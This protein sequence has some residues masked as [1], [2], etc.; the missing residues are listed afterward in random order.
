M[1]PNGSALGFTTSDFPSPHNE[2]TN[3]AANSPLQA[4]LTDGPQAVALFGAGPLAT[5]QAATS[6][7]DFGAT[8][9]GTVNPEY[10]QTTYQFEYGTTTSY[11]H[12]VP[13]T[14]G[15]VG[16]D[17]TT[18]SELATLSGLK[19]ST[20]YHFRIVATN[21]T[22]T[23]DGADMTFKTAAEPKLALKV[24]PHSA[25]AGTKTC[26]AFTVTSSGH[27]TSKATVKLAGHTAKTN[28]NGKAKLCLTLKKGTYKARASKKGF[29]SAA[30]RVRITA[31]SP[32]FT[33]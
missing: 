14:A 3:P 15:S 32:V 1:T 11:G 4:I 29:V 6:I 27:R 31:P 9:H 8:I 20:T 26:F 21:P 5:T 24:S 7:T 2:F 23:T 18:H 25:K 10:G 19:P 28:S 22:G 12:S 33:G 16:S 30:T 17:A 13:A